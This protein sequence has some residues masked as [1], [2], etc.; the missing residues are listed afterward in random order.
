MA[1]P[2]TPAAPTP[3]PAPPA[4]RRRWLWLL[5][6]AAVAGAL[7]VPVIYWVATYLFLNTPLGPSLLGGGGRVTLDWRGG[8]AWVPGRVE[9]RGFSLEGIT[10]RGE[11]RLEIDQATLEHRLRPFL[12]RT[13]WAERIDARGATFRWTTHDGP[14]ELP[15]RRAKKRPGW[16]LH[17]PN[18]DIAGVRR[19]AF[20]DTFVDA[21]VRPGTAELALDL[22]IRGAFE[23]PRMRL[24]LADAVV[25]RS[26]EALGRLRSLEVAGTLKPYEPKV[27]RGAA[28]LR[29]ASGRIDLVSEA[30]NLSSLSSFFRGLPVGLDGRGALDASLV[31]ADGVLEPE[32]QLDVKEAQLGIDYLDY[33]A[34]GVGQLRLEGNIAERTSRLE[35]TVSNF[36]FGHRGAAPH[37]EGDLLR[38][39][40][41]GPVLDLANPEPQFVA[42][43]EIPEARVPDF[44][45]F[46]DAIPPGVPLHI[47][48]GRGAMELELRLD[49]QAL[50]VSGRVALRGD[51]LVAD[52]DQHRVT[53]DLSLQAS[54]TRG[55]IDSRRFAISDV[56][57]DINDVSSGGVD[58]WWARIEILDG[59]ATLGRPLLMSAGATAVLSDA[60]PMAALLLDNE[61]RIA[62]L[63]RV[64][65]EKRV[66]AQADIDFSDSA[67]VIQDLDVTSGRR[68]HSRGDLQLTDG[69]ITG[70]M[71][72]EFGRLAAAA[73]LRNAGERDIKLRGAR[74]WFA[75]RREALSQAPG[76]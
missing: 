53:G 64:L 63:Q 1:E 35:A 56:S 18:I 14:I 72:V 67:L 45:A 11:W 70:L 30:W 2:T 3:S 59:V 54:L 34:E 9:V 32:S 57:L 15:P 69:E 42:E 37:V 22:R 61:R 38:L 39:V 21:A 46:D 47:R 51:D 25:D 36:N 17:F 27:H 20:D 73:E 12:E 8:Q 13:F 4:R 5:P 52:L 60:R 76:R 43:I 16:R 28:A 68:L 31:I 55:D 50:D 74:D 58:G 71:L 26:G 65:D 41:R 66:R 29:F 19:L 44:A 48:S 33:R 6:L 7:A 62:W 75:V 23:A 10:P 40:G 49:P 24:S